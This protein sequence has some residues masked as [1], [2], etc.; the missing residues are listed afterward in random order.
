MPNFKDLKPGDT[1]LFNAGHRPDQDWVLAT[2]KTADSEWVYA[3][4]DP[5]AQNGQESIVMA[6]RDWGHFTNVGDIKPV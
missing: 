5:I 2:V 6:P 4:F 3:K 1:F